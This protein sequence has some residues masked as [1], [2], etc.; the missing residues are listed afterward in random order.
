DF[1]VGDIHGCYGLLMERLRAVDFDESRDRL[2]S[3][4]DLTDRGPNSLEVLG[5]LK[6]PWVHAV[7]GNHDIMLL[8]WLNMYNSDLFSPADFLRNGGA[9]V[10]ELSEFELA[11]LYEQFAPLLASL[12]YVRMVPGVNGNPGFNL[13]HAVLILSYDLNSGSESVFTDEQ[14]REISHTPEWG[15]KNRAL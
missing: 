3:V 14:L 1:V 11:S 6:K 13:V 5:L 2:Y 4:G 10:T 12:P 15:G 7:Q 9:W 8:N